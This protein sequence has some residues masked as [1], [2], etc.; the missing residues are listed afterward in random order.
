MFQ[1]RDCAPLG[2]IVAV[3]AIIS[4]GIILLGNL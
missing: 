3:A 2:V 4:L 1:R